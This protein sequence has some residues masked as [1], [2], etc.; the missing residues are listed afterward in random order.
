MAQRQKT[1]QPKSEGRDQIGS[2]PL[3]S[4]YLI[5]SGLQTA[6]AEPIALRHRME[7]QIWEE[8]IELNENTGSN[9]QPRGKNDRSRRKVLEKILHKVFS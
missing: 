9:N 7:Q 2:H 8:A 4:N 6:I 3:N 5:T 1:Q